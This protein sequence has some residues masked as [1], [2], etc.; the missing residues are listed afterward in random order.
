MTR[1]HPM[2]R[3]GYRKG[4]SMKRTEYRKS[5][6]ADLRS[7]ERKRTV[8]IARRII[9]FSFLCRKTGCWV[10]TGSKCGGSR[11]FP[12]KYGKIK[13]F[14][15]HYLLHILFCEH[16]HGPRPPGKQVRHI[17][18]NASCFNPK[19]LAWSTDI[20]NKADKL[21]HGTDLRGQKHPKAK[22][23]ASQVLEIR[24]SEKTV[25]QLCEV[26]GVGDSTIRKILN[27]ENWGWL[28]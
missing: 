12:S 8:S 6:W 17:C 25:K 20:E 18:G 24:E 7:G 9:R 16:R 19:H 21:I 23:K 26:Y 13:I 28:K 22:L 27:R 15:K 3:S 4:N 5:H 2:D 1:R 10:W 14:G 11:G